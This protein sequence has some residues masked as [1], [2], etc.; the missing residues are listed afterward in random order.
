MD[1]VASSVVL[2]VVS[3]VVL[4]VVVVV[5]VVDVTVCDLG[6]SITSHLHLNPLYSF[7]LFDLKKI[8]IFLPK[9]RRLNVLGMFPHSLET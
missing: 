9:E 6:A 3:S 7:T 2:D 8:S 5:A 4:D 1:D